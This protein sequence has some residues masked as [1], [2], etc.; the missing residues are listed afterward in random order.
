PFERG[1]LVVTLLGAGQF[2]FEVVA[3]AGPGTPPARVPAF[4]HVGKNS[5]VQDNCRCYH[6]KPGSRM[7]FSEANVD[8]KCCGVPSSLTDPQWTELASGSAG[9]RVPRAPAMPG[10]AAPA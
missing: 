4:A 3:R 7:S 2:A 9:R 10:A 6:E 1:R 5:A 8:R